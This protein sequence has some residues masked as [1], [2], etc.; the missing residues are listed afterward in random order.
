MPPERRGRRHGLEEPLRR[1]RAPLHVYVLNGL[2]TNPI[3]KTLQEER[4][5]GPAATEQYRD[6]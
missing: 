6:S 1:G 3:A 2:A 4:A 5:A